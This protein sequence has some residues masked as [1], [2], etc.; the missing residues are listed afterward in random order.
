MSPGS[1][2]D[3]GGHLLRLS[4]S[5]S[6]PPDFPC[7]HG[8]VGM[9]DSGHWVQ[10]EKPEVLLAAIDGFLPRLVAAVSYSQGDERD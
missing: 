8:L 10:A 5:D 6:G 2:L 7:L 4:V 3:V 1:K 9:P